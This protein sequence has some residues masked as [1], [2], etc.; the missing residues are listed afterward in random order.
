MPYPNVLVIMVDQMK[1]TASH[2]YGNTFCETPHMARMAEEG[3]L[4]RHAVTPHPLC[5][6]ARVSLWTG[7]WP[8]SHGARRNETLMPPDATHA[9]ALWKRLGF[10]CGLIGKNHCFETAQ[11]LALFDTWNEIGHGG[12]PRG[13]RHAGMP[14]FRPRAA[15]DDAHSVR[16]QMPDIS[17]RFT[18][19]VS[20]YPLEDYSTGLV[21]G[22]TV[23]FLEA[24]RDEPFA[25]WV[26]FP[27][28][29]T[30][31]EVPRRYA[32]MIPPEAVELPPSR[33]EEW[34]S[35]PERNQVLR[36]ILGM[37]DDPIEHVRGVLSV[38]HAMVRFLDDGLG[39][40]LDALDRL[41]LRRRTIVV[42]TSDHGDC[43]GEHN[44]ISKGG[45]FWDCL[46]RIPMIV[47]CPGSV[48][49][50]QVDES[51][52]NL[53]DVVPTLL[54]LQGIAIPRS[55]H[56]QPLPTVTTAAPRDVTFSEY[57]AGGPPFTVADLL[58]LPP[59]YGR[60]TVMRS[61]RWREAEGRRK[62]AR[63]R[64]WKYVHD[65]MGDRDELYDLANDPWELHN[66]A[67]DPAYRTAL[68]AMARRLGD[69]S[70][71]TEDARPVPLPEE[72]YYHLT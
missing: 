31:Y 26:S 69:W 17:P 39:Q 29:H 56:G 67:D 23:R 25:L 45:A 37:E 21:A 51:M 38:Y 34:T 72:S 13:A 58:T 19:A 15:I 14:W 44:M 33:E 47:S 42:F 11:D 43:S 54:E 66:V 20:D 32:E 2:L 52:A 53:V 18:Y 27:D 70:I 6:P 40:I 22:Q 68:E 62:M 65:P 48:P 49:Q 30:P 71:Q 16:R 1:A 59:P 7:Q 8:H 55:M 64:E 28:P 61:L 35:A 57:G 4:F 50:G 12:I 41:D 24:H 3:V 10:H 63:T 5:V 36:Y 46:T 60:S 9:F